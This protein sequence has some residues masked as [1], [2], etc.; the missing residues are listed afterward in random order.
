MG[1]IVCCTC[2][3]PAGGSEGPAGL[4]FLPLPGLSPPPTPLQDSLR[5][6][7]QV[8][9]AGGYSLAHRAAWGDADTLDCSLTSPVCIMGTVILSGRVGVRIKGDVG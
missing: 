2:E 7:P 5:T 8:E 9:K 6:W 1:S 4:C 3:L